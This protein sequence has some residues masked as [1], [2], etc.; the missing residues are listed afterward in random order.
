MKSLRASAWVFI[1]AAL[2]LLGA[3]IISSLEAGEPVVRSMR[4]ILNFLPGVDV[5]ANSG[6]GWV[7]VITDLPLWAVLG[8]L[9]LIA[10][11]IVR[12]VD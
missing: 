12:P 3:D 9:G 2:A 6:P 11:L 8:I 1:A 10:T 5:A 4:E 7:R